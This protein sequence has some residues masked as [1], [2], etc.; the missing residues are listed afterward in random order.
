MKVFV[1]STFS[2]LRYVRESLETFLRGYGMEPVLFERGGIVYPP[3]QKLEEACN[4]S[5]ADCDIYILIIGGKYGSST[6]GVSQAATPS[7]YRS[8]TRSEFVYAANQQMPCYVFIDKN[9][10]S[11]Y[12]TYIANDKNQ[13]LNYSGIDDNQI[14][15]F[16]D[17]ISDA[18]RAQNLSPMIPYDRVE[19]IIFHLSKQLPGLFR[20]LLKSHREAVQHLEV[21]KQIKELSSLVHTLKNYVEKIIEQTYP[22]HSDEII[23]NEDARL[24]NESLF[25]SVVSNPSLSLLATTVGETIEKLFDLAK[26]SEHEAAFVETILQMSNERLLS[27]E[28]AARELRARAVSVYSS[29]NQDQIP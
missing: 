11:Q 4:I 26:E 13:S 18:R 25:I 28:S 8:I 16:I 27:N 9:V 15:D 29:V 24:H 12:E 10:R 17:E 22:N 23:K 2:D 5:V 3:R 7:S 20:L 21:D 6:E 1:S 19:D 14:F